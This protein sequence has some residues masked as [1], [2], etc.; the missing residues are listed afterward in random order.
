[1]KKVIV[2]GSSGMVGQLILQLCL[3]E[4]SIGEVIS[5]VR[6]PLPLSHA[7]LR[8][9]VVED[10]LHYTPHEE[11]FKGVDAVYYCVGV[12]TGAVPRDLFRMI[13]VDYPMALAQ[14]I[15]KHSPK[16][17]FVLL[18]GQGADRQEKSR[19]MFAKDKGEVEN[20]LEALLGP[21]FFTCRPGYIYPVQKR[22]EPNFSY[23]LSRKLYPVL[24]LLGKKLSITSEELVLAMFLIGLKKPQKT[25]F[26]NDELREYLTVV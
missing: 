8:E 15:K 23:V 21:L 10:F 7:K 4:K 25:L 12:Y 14:A 22:K 26:E 3:N 24:K 18:S 19:M 9:I 17:A 20:K 16:S 11:Q 6:K 2:A 13:T 5:L 1:M